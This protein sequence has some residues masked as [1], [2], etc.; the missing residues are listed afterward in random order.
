[1]ALRGEAE[2]L[3]TLKYAFLAAAVCL[4]VLC[5]NSDTSVICLDV[6]EGLKWRKKEFLRGNPRR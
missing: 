4:C 5:Q 2:T 1:M 6:L 3:W